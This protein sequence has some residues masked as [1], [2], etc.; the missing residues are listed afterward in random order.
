TF[1]SITLL[2][3]INIYGQQPQD[4]GSWSQP[5]PFEIVPVAV[6]NLP[7]GRLVTW[8]AE[9]K[10]SFSISNG[11]THYELFD[12]FQ[13]TDGVA[14]VFNRTDCCSERLDGVKVYV[15]N[16]GT[17]NPDDYH[18]VGTLNSDIQQTF[19]S[20]LSSGRYI[21]VR[22]E[23]SEYLSLAEVQAFGAPVVDCTGANEVIPEIRI[24]VLSS[25]NLYV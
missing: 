25:D 17:S 2:L 13:G 7:D 12:P 9:A 19:T 18:E 1:I 4:V 21:M 20:N 22:H 14:L 24:D 6:A 3:S 10:L 15:G 5:I 11:L 23:K 16:N 8:S